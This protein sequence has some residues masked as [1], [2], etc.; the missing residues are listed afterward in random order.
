MRLETDKK[1]T[2]SLPGPPNRAAPLAVVSNKVKEGI[3]ARWSLTAF[4]QN[5]AQ[6]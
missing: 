4:A 1:L 3:P 5:N 6:T 2:V